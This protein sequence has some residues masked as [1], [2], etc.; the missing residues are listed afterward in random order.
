[1]T[2]FRFLFA[3]VLGLFLTFT[4]GASAQGMIHTGDAIRTKSVGPFTAKVYAIRHD[5]AS[6]PPQKTKQAVIDADVNKVFTWVMLRDVDSSKIQKALRDAFAMNGYGDAGK[7]G[8]FVGAFSKEEV[9]EKSTVVI[10]Y[11]ATSKAVTIT[12]KD[13]SSATVAG[14]DFMKAVWRIWLGKIDQPSMGDQLIAKLPG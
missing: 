5:M 8:Q 9:K 11:N 12:V 4:L 13:G 7:I 3:V 6:A 1:M 10:S 14:A 2:R